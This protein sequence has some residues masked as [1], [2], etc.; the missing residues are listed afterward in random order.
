M[1]MFP[2]S[3]G[4]YWKIVLIYT[5]D[6][7]GGEREREARLIRVDRWEMVRDLRRTTNNLFEFVHKH[8]FGVLQ[9]VRFVLLVFMGSVERH[10]VLTFGRIE[11]FTPARI[12]E[13]ASIKD[14]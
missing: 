8:E 11:M 1:G 6:F 10:V 2:E 7:F 13:H 9:D 5:I 12:T 3:I 4:R 14:S